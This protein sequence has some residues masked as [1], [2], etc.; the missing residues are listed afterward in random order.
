M[1]T[2]TNLMPPATDEA[3]QQALATTLLAN[4]SA[5]Q[6][7]A[8]GRLRD[9]QLAADAI[10]ESLL[11]AL[12]SGRAPSLDGNVVVWFYRILRNVLTDLHRRRNAHAKALERFAAE[13]STHSFD[14]EL[15]KQ[16]CACL[17]SLLPTLKP[18]YAQVLQL[19][20]LEV[21]PADQVAE[22]LGVSRGNLKVRL[23]RAR[24]Q[25]RERLEQTCQAC[26]TH[27]CLDCTCEGGA[28]QHA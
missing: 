7:F 27:G 1:V 6:S 24:K 4:L 13:E 15:Q 5:F 17:H 12:K 25:L 19:A 8:R 2:M 16:A 11:R 14:D 28:H 3:A 10:Q 21:K 20:D 26:A 22:E 18:E 9:E 23:H